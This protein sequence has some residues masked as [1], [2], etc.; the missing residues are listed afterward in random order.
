MEEPMNNSQPND[1][2]TVATARQ[3]LGVSHT[4]MS[5]L[6]RD[7]LIRYFPNPLDGREKL[8]SKAEVIALIPKRAEA[9]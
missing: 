4:K 8:I 6:I 1:L 5:Q 2:I 9:A 3:L 7:G